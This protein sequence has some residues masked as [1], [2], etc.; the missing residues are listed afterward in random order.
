MRL[1]L[2]LSFVLVILVTIVSVVLF[3]RLSNPREVRAFMF[4]GGMAGSQELVNDLEQY[5]AQHGS[6]QGVEALLDSPHGQGN[7]PGGGAGMGAMMGQRLQ[8]A[9]ASGRLVADSNDANPTGQL[10]MTE[11]QSA[12]PLVDSKGTVIGYLLA[13]GGMWFPPSIEQPLLNRLNQAAM[14]AGLVAGVIGLALALVLAYRFLRPID[15][16]T[17]AASRISHGDLSQ[18]VQVNTGDEVGLL[19]RTFNLMAASLEKAEQNRRAMTAD[20]AHE[21]RTPLAVQRAQL[22]ALQDGIY[23][24]NTENLQPLLD[25]N[26]LLSRLVD[27]LRT[28]ALADAGELSLEL[29]PTDFPALIGRIVE[30]FQPEARTRGVELSFECASVCD[31]LT[32]NLDSARIEQILTNLL[33][34]ALRYTPAGG[35]VALTLR[36]SSRSAELAVQDSGPGISPEDLAH[37]FERFYRADRARSREDGGTGL[38]L[39]IARQLARAHGGDLLAANHPAGGA[40][41]TLK[42]PTQ[43]V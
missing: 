16:L 23:P 9:D 4:R 31:N 41:F 28:L 3:V 34:N 37:I 1:R 38:G 8:V 12:I 20:I 27:D 22:E 13:A 39:A 42:L 6:W 33:S 40:I 24:L 32:L 15:Q 7:G 35:R 43:K 26:R 25:Q 11:L 18:R 36:C 14:L 30:R 21:L 10:P 2:I 17:R 19:A 5:Y 29:A